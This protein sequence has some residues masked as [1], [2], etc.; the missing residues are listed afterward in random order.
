MVEDKVGQAIRRYAS[1]VPAEKMWAGHTKDRL[2]CKTR[3]F[4]ADQ[5]K[6]LGMSVADNAVIIGEVRRT[7]PNQGKASQPDAEVEFQTLLY[8]YIKRQF[9]ISETQ[10][11]CFRLGIN[12]E[13][14]PHKNLSQFTREL[15]NYVQ[16]HGRMKELVTLVIQL[17]PDNKDAPP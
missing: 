4:L 3:D 17:R 12:Y 1:Y 2:E 15:I 5:I 14:I 13:E 6:A 7:V 16:R 9:N 8:L 10:D 11:I